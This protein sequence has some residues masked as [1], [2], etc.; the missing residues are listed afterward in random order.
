V[1]GEGEC[2]TGLV[3]APG[4]GGLLAAPPIRMKRAARL[5][6]VGREER[7]EPQRRRDILDLVQSASLDPG[8]VLLPAPRLGLVFSRQVTPTIRSFRETARHSTVVL[9]AH[10]AMIST[11]FPNVS[12]VSTTSTSAIGRSRRAS[13]AGSSPTSAR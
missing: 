10:A 3:V 13:E 5:R 12:P 9:S 7:G 11:K 6:G 2:L 8:G 4:H 1:D